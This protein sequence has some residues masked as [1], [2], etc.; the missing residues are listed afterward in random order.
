MS[1]NGFRI[2]CLNGM[3]VILLGMFAGGIPLV[4]V[5]VQEAY[6]HAPAIHGSEAYRGWMMAH[7]EGLL[8]G[9]L[10]IIVAGSTRILPLPDSQERLLVPAL[11]VAGWGNAIASVLAP[12]WGVRGMIFDNHAANNLVALIFTAALAGTI[13]AMTIAIRQ[14][15]GWLP[16]G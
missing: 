11:M 14:L 3:V 16:P 8:N 2:V 7:L 13:V 12:F 15:A 9:L 1:D 4:F 5:V 6:K 10:M